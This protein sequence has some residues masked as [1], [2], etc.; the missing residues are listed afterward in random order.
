[1]FKSKTRS[2]TNCGINEWILRMFTREGLELTK[3]LEGAKLLQL[4]EEEADLVL[5]DYRKKLAKIT[6]I[7]R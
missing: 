7:N 3:K 5:S 4:N 6:E 2:G 1:M